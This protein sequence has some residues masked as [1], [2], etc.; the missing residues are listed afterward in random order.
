M[1][2]KL[3]VLVVMLMMCAGM[4]YAQ[5]NTKT[6]TGTATITVYS[7]LGGSTI[8]GGKLVFGSVAPGAPAV[9]ISPKSNKAAGFEFTGRDGAG[10]DVTYPTSIPM[11]NG[12][13]ASLT[14]DQVEAGY[15]TA[16]SQNNAT[17]DNSGSFS[18]NLGQG[19]GKEDG[20]GKLDIWIGGTVKTQTSTPSGDYTGNFTVKV[21][22]TGT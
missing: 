20:G 1:F 21:A 22:Y 12:S 11:S 18:T 3:S 19:D 17:I 16:G 8:N 7:S 15:S 13:G 5:N 6:A 10:V 4:S 2:K 14:V 9:T